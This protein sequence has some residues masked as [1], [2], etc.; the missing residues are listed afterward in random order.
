MHLA[1]N[2]SSTSNASRTLRL[3]ADS[4]FGKIDQVISIG[5]FNFPETCRNVSENFEERASQWE[6]T[7]IVRHL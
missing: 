4:I 2:T 5:S 1:C 7:Y 6:K 3:P